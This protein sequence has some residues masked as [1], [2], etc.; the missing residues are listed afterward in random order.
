M[1]L[2]MSIVVLL[3]SFSGSRQQDSEISITP[4]TG[5]KDSS[6]SGGG[7]HKCGRNS[8][9]SG[10]APIAG[11]LPAAYL[12]MHGHDGLPKDAT[13]QIQR[14]VEAMSEEMEQIRV[15]LRKRL[16]RIAEL[17][18]EIRDLVKKSRK[19][20]GALASSSSPTP[21][22]PKDSR[23]A[24]LGCLLRDAEADGQFCNCDEDQYCEASSVCNLDGQ[25]CRRPSLDK[26][27]GE[28][29]IDDLFENDQTPD[30]EWEKILFGRCMF[31]D[32]RSKWKWHA[33][34]T[35]AASILCLL[36]CV[37]GLLFYVIM[38]LRYGVPKSC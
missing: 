25:D 33:I 4:D 16:P 35:T 1:L 9:F 37:S 28:W 5:C 32:S 12:E 2:V 36:S 26:E 3:P 10:S 20:E 30:K 19:K 22:C 18:N 17:E 15:E 31:P 21:A 23:L 13:D 11:A 7:K 24:G 6:Q 38:K 14:W 8:S 27:S 34:Y 29:S